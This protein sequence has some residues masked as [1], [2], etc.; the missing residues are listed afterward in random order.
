MMIPVVSSLP[1]PS[2]P[3]APGAADRFLAAWARLGGTWE[4]HANPTSARLGLL[5]YLRDL[6]AHQVLAWPARQLPLPGL[7]DALRD[8]G[9]ILVEADRQA[10][11]AGLDI[12][13]TG[14]DAG[15]IETGSLVIES[16]PGRSWLPALLPAHHI[17]ILPSRRLYP[18]L[19]AWRSQQTGREQETAGTLIITGPSISA[20]IEF[21]RHRGTF[22]PRFLH[23]IL[24]EDVRSE[25]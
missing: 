5:R 13:L 9:F 15:L 4:Q 25:E 11:N 14:A 10:P 7:A 21:H 18:S 16:L 22:G 8:T 24:V 23:L 17:V 1:M 19:A 20:D 12:G 2:D 3:P 6:Q